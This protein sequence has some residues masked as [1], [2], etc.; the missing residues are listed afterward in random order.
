[1]L[2]IKKPKGHRKKTPKGHLFLFPFEYSPI[3][4]K[5]SFIKENMW[6]AL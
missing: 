5:D 6:E 1:M 2:P 4:R 3:N